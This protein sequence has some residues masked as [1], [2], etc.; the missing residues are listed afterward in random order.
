MRLLL[1]ELKVQK[2]AWWEESPAMGSLSVHFNTKKPFTTLWWGHVCIWETQNIPCPCVP[3]PELLSLYASQQPAVH[4]GYGD[5]SYE[6]H[7]QCENKAKWRRPLDQANQASPAT[8]MWGSHFPPQ[9][10]PSDLET[11]WPEVILGTGCMHN[12]MIVGILSTVSCIW[13]QL[14]TI[15]FE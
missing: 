3:L 11:L 5:L 6:T 2:M 8:S 15:N 1:T 9:S 10:H 7:G 14:P 12:R 13:L 4:V